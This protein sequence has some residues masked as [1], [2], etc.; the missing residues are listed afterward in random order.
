M[1]QSNI[2]NFL[3]LTLYNE[4]ILY[5][6]EINVKDWPTWDMVGMVSGHMIYDTELSLKVF[7]L[8][9]VFL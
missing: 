9:F 2:Y 1:E 8:T 4:A 5:A 6:A 3:L 7:D